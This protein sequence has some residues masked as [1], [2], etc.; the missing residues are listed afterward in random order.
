MTTIYV[1]TA[2]C[3]VALTLLVLY[4]VISFIIKNRAGRIAFIRSFKK[5]KCVA[6]FLIAIP[7]IFLGYW[8]DG[9]DIIHSLLTAIPHVIGF[10]VL[11]YD[12][13]KIASLMEVNLFYSITIY[14]CCVLVTLNAVLFAFSLT[15]QLIWQM[16]WAVKAKHNNKDAIYIFGYNQDNLSIYQS[17]KSKVKFIVDDI[18]AENCTSMYIKKINFLNSKSYDAIISQIFKLILK[19]GCRYTVVINT[20]NDDKNLDIS[21]LF[22]DKVKSLNDADKQK[23]FECLSVFVFGNPK[24]ESIYADIVSASFGCVHYK[25][26][27][28]MIAMDFINKHPFTEF[29][30]E[31]HIDYETSLIKNDVDINVCMIG[32]GKT[33]QQIFMTSVANN[34]F[35]TSAQQSVALKMVNYHLFDKN[36]AE[37]NKNLNH[38]YYRFKNECADINSSNYLPLPEL[39]ATETYYH[40]DINEPAFYNRIREITTKNSQDVNIIIIAFNNDLENIDM[41]QKLVEKRREWGIDNLVI[42]V[43]VRSPKDGYTLFNEEKVIIIGNEKEVVF[44]INAISN[45]SIF[46]MAQM[47]NEIYD[48][49]YK[50]KT[51]KNFIVDEAAIEENR[52]NANRNWF[53]VKSQLERESSLYS[54]LSLKLKLNLL[55]LD[56]CGINDN[57]L[58]ALTEQ[59]YLSCYGVGDM[60]DTSTYGK[61]IEGKK[62]VR[63]DL[64]FLESKRKNL[65]VL[66][67]YRWNSFMIS[68]GMIPASKAQILNE[69]VDKNGK[70][71]FT[72]G[73]NYSLRRHGNLTTF[74]GL[75]DFRKMIAQRDNCQEI[76][77]DVIKYDYQIL[78]DAYWLLTNNG[79]KIVRRYEY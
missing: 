72:N 61:I 77:C 79:Y 46:R 31:R 49:E 65:A 39:P 25:N 15:S 14:Y 44:N 13:D 24:Y 7:L 42:F 66:E 26:K 33:N 4:F 76:E 45:D 62:I 30:D 3:C 63:Y 16:G 23:L 52:D 19:N 48:L 60:P 32:F 10:V 43:K 71:K 68:K 47:R 70:L 28:Q 73:K 8:Y 53:I 67:H 27:Y 12:V 35:L 54:C 50:I 2:L 74:E 78:D 56:Y 22:V 1:I 59:E 29:M 64:N 41:A 55:G 11:K 40:L 36:Y 17:D 37:N 5:G 51:D 34:Q 57:D 6:I 18:S 75:M 58:P 69:T 21:W 9:L 38:S 20:K